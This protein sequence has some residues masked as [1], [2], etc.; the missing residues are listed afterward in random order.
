MR[1]EAR[2]YP[3]ARHLVVLAAE[4]FKNGQAVAAEQALPVYVRDEVAKKAGSAGRT[5]GSAF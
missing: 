2:I 3:H 5:D 4:A 1:R